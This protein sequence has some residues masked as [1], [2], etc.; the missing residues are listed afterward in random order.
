[1][2][3]IWP[4]PLCIYKLVRSNHLCVSIIEY[5]LFNQQMFVHRLLNYKKPL[6]NTGLT[7]LILIV[8]SLPGVYKMSF[9]SVMKWQKKLTNHPIFVSG[10]SSVFL[11]W[12]NPGRSR[13]I[14]SG[15]K[16]FFN[17]LSKKPITTIYMSVNH[18]QMLSELLQT[19]VVKAKF[20]RV[21]KWPLVFSKHQ[22]PV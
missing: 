21:G 13:I 5:L 12:V 10:C 6:G 3:N 8:F 2:L 7:H 17:I 20:R 15:V 14:H 22:S 9:H 19:C 1:M 11:L 4:M 16:R 18:I